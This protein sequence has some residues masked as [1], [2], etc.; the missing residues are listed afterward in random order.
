[1]PWQLGDVARYASS[2]IKSHR[3]SNFG[4]ALI[5][6]PI[7]ISDG[8]LIGVYDF[9]AAVYGLNGLLLL[10][11]NFAIDDCSPTWQLTCRI[12]DAGIAVAPVMT[13]TV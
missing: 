3:P 7:D 10:H 11:N 4:I 2:L 8:L 9:E 1:V 5:R 6:V 13:I 12:D